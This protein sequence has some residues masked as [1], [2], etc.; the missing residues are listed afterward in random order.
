MCQQRSLN[1]WTD[2]PGERRPKTR[3][4]KMSIFEYDFADLCRFVPVAE[5]ARF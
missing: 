5:A 4:L 1:F 2:C 3:G